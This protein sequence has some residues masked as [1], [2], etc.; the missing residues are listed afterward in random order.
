MLRGGRTAGDIVSAALA[1]AEKSGGGGAATAA[2]ELTD[3]AVF[4]DNCSGKRI[5]IIAFFKDI[6]DECVFTGGG[7]GIWEWEWWCKV[8]A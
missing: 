6:L 3:Q 5:C 7:G 8:V 1:A 4:D 2:V